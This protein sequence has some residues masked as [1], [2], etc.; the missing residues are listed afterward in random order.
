MKEST[1]ISLALSAPPLLVWQPT[2]RTLEPFGF[3]IAVA[4]TALGVALQWQLPRQRIAMEERI[5]DGLLTE[6]EANRRLRF[7]AVCAPVATL[8]GV[9]ML[10]VVLLDFSD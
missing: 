2:V 6:K 3:S 10:L 1:A 5:K 9:A 4:M 8:A 7:Y